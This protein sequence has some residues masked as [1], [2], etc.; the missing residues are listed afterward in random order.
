MDT[1]KD[2]ITSSRECLYSLRRFMSTKLVTSGCRTLARVICLCTALTS[3]STAWHTQNC[4]TN[5]YAL[6]RFCTFCAAE[7]MFLTISRVG[8]SNLLAISNCQIGASSCAAWYLLHCLWR[9]RRE[10]KSRWEI[11][12]NCDTKHL[13]ITLDKSLKRGVWSDLQQSV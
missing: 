4:F 13:F 8:R 10:C 12:L 5:S 1:P 2:P 11:C 6:I 9:K 7:N 3:A